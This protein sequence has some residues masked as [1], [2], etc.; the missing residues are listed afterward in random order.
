[1]ANPPQRTSENE[2]EK[3]SQITKIHEWAKTAHIDK[4]KARVPTLNI[5]LVSPSN[6]ISA[7][8][9]GDIMRA[10]YNGKNAYCGLLGNTY[11]ARSIIY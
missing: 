3:E 1:M 4:P 2:Q 7:T 6:F 10:R 11:T 8:R 5:L 9:R